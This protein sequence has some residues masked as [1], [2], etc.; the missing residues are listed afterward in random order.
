MVMSIFIYNDSNAFNNMRGSS[1]WK[2][3]T[4]IRYVACRDATFNMLLS[5]ASNNFT[6]YI[7]ATHTVRMTLE[8]EERNEVSP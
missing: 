8:R 2:G 7:G 4:G 5:A 3:S 1:R 6:V